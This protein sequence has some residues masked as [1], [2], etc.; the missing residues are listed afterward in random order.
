MRYVSRD[1]T[2][3]AQKS[4]GLRTASYKKYSILDVNFF[5]RNNFKDI[6]IYIYIYIQEY[7]D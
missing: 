1:V 6:Y 3:H 7:H 5:R 2:F 4:N